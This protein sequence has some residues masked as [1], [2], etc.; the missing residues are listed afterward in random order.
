MGIDEKVKCSKFNEQISIPDR[1]R[2]KVAILQKPFEEVIYN[3]M[4]RLSFENCRNFCRVSYAS[5]QENTSLRSKNAVIAG[6]QGLIEKKHVIK[7]LNDD[8]KP[9]MNR[10]GTLYRILSPDEI[11]NCR[12]AEGLLIDDIDREGMKFE[13]VEQILPSISKNNNIQKKPEEEKHYTQLG[14]RHNKEPGI[15]RKKRFA[16]I[17]IAAILMIFAVFIA[18]FHYYG[19]GGILN[20]TRQKISNRDNEGRENNKFSQINE[21]IDD[22]PLVKKS[23]KKNIIDTVTSNMKEPGTTNREHIVEN[24][25]RNEKNQDVN[26]NMD[27]NNNTPDSVGQNIKDYDNI[28]GKGSAN[29]QNET[30]KEER[31]KKHS[32][33]KNAIDKGKLKTIINKTA[34]KTESIDNK[35]SN[36]ANDDKSN[37]EKQKE[38]KNEQTVNEL[39]KDVKP[40]INENDNKTDTGKK[41]KEKP[42]EKPLDIID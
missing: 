8:N 1:D 2:V 31:R 23:E 24:N 13:V 40:S 29:P 12:L 5:I 26:S 30:K 27:S 6:I 19:T 20:G 32:T 22:R 7:L 14:Y 33:N 38:S 21:A 18:L 4:L 15:W 25:N 11:T 9:E 35:D 37:E 34:S 10:E 16:I 39:K 17:G 41:Q 28:K 3:H 36:S 42:E